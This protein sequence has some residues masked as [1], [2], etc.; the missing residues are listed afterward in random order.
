MEDSLVNAFP[1]SKRTAARC[2]NSRAAS[3]WVAWRRA[4]KCMG[5]NTTRLKLAAF[6][7]AAMWAGFAGVLWCAKNN[8]TNPEFF[9]FMQSII[10]LAMVVLGGMGS[11]PGAIVGAILLYAGPAL[12]RIYLPEFQQ[13]RLLL[14]GALMVLLMIYRP[15]GLFGS[16]RLK[17]QLAVDE[18][19]ES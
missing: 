3:I 11:I 13:Y 10:I 14:F 12:L 16:A 19:G 17:A 6:A 15:Q 4:A 9:N 1:F 7:F 5:I 2:V 18:E 8:Y